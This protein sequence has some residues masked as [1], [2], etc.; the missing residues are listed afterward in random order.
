MKKVFGIFDYVLKPIC[1]A[2]VVLG[3]MSGGA[4]A[5]GT[6]CDDESNDMINGDFALC[7]VHAYNIWETENTEDNK[8]LMREVVAMKTT[9]ITQQMYKQYEQIDSMVR[10]L[11]TQLEKATLKTKFQYAGANSDDSDGGSGTSKGGDLIGINE[12]NYISDTDD[13]LICYERNLTT[14]RSLSSN[15]E[16]LSTA[17]K[18]QLGKDFKGL[19]EM[20]IYDGRETKV[21]CDG[22]VKRDSDKYKMCTNDREESNKIKYMNKSEFKE[23]VDYMVS[24]L[25]NA[26]NAYKNGERSYSNSWNSRN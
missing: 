15:G 10:R 23:C 24:C 18:K 8:D 17:H 3:L 14:I 22:V 20:S 11:K 13:A 7:S 12:C 5:A 4:R 2:V 9:L 16:N 6:G 19:F 21:Q 25:R 26:K 1:M